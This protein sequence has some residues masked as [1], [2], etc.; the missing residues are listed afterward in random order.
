MVVVIEGLGAHKSVTIIT[1]FVP[2]VTSFVIGKTM[3]KQWLRKRKARKKRVTGNYFFYTR[4][5]IPNRGPK[6]Y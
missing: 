6:R 2:N 1:K 5:E 3:V 4:V